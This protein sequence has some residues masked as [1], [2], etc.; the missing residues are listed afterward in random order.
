MTEAPLPG[1]TAEPI[2]V[3]GVEQTREIAL[4][5]VR[6]GRRDA[7]ILA[8]R[9]DP[10]VYDQAAFVDA[11]VDLVRS[12]RNSRARLLVAEP[13]SLI[14]YDHRLVGLAQ[15]LGSRV[16]IRELA[17]QHASLEEDL[18]VVDE[19][20]LLHRI[21]GRRYT[22]LANFNDRREARRLARW[23]DELWDQAS[24]AV[25]LRRLGL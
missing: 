15:R 7:R 6:R 11:L 12:H 18:L 4:A 1:E 16:E 13:E 21:Q 8:R 19:T 23:F 20:G 22:G 3:E 17:A 5:L 24:P 10:P 9:L 2:S 25:G 14:R